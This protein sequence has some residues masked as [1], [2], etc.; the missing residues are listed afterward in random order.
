MKKY[1]SHLT[2]FLFLFSLLFLG[3]MGNGEARMKVG[4]T[5]LLEQSISCASQQ[6]EYQAVIKKAGATFIVVHFSSF[7]LAEGDTVEI[8]DSSGVVRE[9][10]D[11]SY[12]GAFWAPAVDGD[13]ATLILNSNSDGASSFTIDSYGFGDVDILEESSLTEST[14]GTD[15]KI[16]R[17]CHKGSYRYEYAA[18][19][20]RML[21]QSGTLWYNCTGSLLSYQNHFMT[22]NHCISN[23][24]EANTLQVRWGY[25]YT[26]CGG[27]TLKSY[28]TTTGSTLVWTSAGLDAT[29][30][31]INS[32]SYNP[33]L[34]HGYLAVS[35]RALISDEPIYIP[36][37][38]AG[39]PKKIAAQNDGV[40]W[41]T[42]PTPMTTESGYNTNASFLHN[43]D[44]VGGTSGS[45]V[46][47]TQNYVIGLHHTGYASSPYS[48]T[49][50]HPSHPTGD[51]ADGY[52]GAILMSAIFP[53]IK[54]HLPADVDQYATGSCSGC[55]GWVWA[56]VEETWR[57]T[58][59]AQERMWAYFRESSPS[60]LWTDAKADVLRTRMLTEAAAS[61]HWLGTYWWSS[62]TVSNLRLYYY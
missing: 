17:E 37:H 42:A 32:T 31:T 44:T 20:G 19:V 1:L 11:S 30:L 38:P 40:Y 51:P 35:G 14:C 16:D 29:L 22:N 26:T 2:L 36:Q 6:N 15:D 24:T 52:N 3:L 41:A 25:E 54:G 46:L 27:S 43:A 34:N 5:Q 50:L 56:H 28:N 18:P 8:I 4:D 60:Y 21:F 59:G 61:G 10:L 39:N 49:S 55:S 23:Q 53:N 9:T 48:C 62:T 58:S 7:E 12:D 47:D 57:Y 13:E 33:A 45:P